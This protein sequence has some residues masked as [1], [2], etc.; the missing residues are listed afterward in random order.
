MT[1]PLACQ[2]CGRKYSAAI[3]EWS[4]SEYVGGP[5]DGEVE[6]DGNAYFAV[7][8][9]HGEIAVDRRKVEALEG[10]VEGGR[11]YRS[12]D[13]GVRHVWTGDKY[14]ER[15]P[16]KTEPQVSERWLADRDDFDAAL[17]IARKY[18]EKY[19]Q[20]E[21]PKERPMVTCVCVSDPGEAPEDL[22]AGG[23][24]H[25]LSEAH[26][27]LVKAQKGLCAFEDLRAAAH[28]ADTI[29]EL[30]PEAAEDMATVK[31]LALRILRRHG[32]EPFER[33]CYECG[34]PFRCADLVMVRG[35]LRCKD[36]HHCGGAA[37]WIMGG[38]GDSVDGQGQEPP[39]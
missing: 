3:D 39:K 21:P 37:A 7:C 11:T 38:G 24:E 25:S 8:P 5:H 28:R 1:H 30:R 14:E 12:V 20:V 36:C 6:I 15:K 33:K 17:P 4:K 32:H 16:G 22:A 26:G 10:H 27:V 23:M 19:A 34:K 9:E 31:A 2:Q 13:T 18:E 29:A 35:T